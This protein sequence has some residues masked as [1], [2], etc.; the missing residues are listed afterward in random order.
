MAHMPPPPMGSTQAIPMQG[1]PE[2]SNFRTPNSLFFGHSSSTPKASRPRSRSF[3]MSPTT[4]PN[5]TSPVASSIGQHAHTTNEATRSRSPRPRNQS[6][7]RD[8]V[9]NRIIRCQVC[10]QTYEPENLAE[11]I[12]NFTAGQAHSIEHLE[13]NVDK[14]FWLLKKFQGTED[15]DEWFER[16]RHDSQGRTISLQR[17]TSMVPLNSTSN[18]TNKRKGISEGDEPPSK[19]VYPYQPT[20]YVCP[21]LCP[22]PFTCLAPR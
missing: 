8:L 2:A 12:A 14:L 20:S 11:A 3:N 22:C 9:A 19:R 5:S 15:A 21:R 10:N 13:Q 6:P 17:G 1:N 16:H 18:P 4:A 7:A